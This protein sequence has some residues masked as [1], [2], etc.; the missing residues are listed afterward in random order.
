M[1]EI[2]HNSGYVALGNAIVAQAAYDY[3]N[4]LELRYKTPGSL[5]GYYRVMNLENFLRSEWCCFISSIDSEYI[6]S[7]CRKKVKQ[8]YELRRNDD[9][10]S[11]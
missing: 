4:A 2:K 7:Y 6:I 10:Q 11:I 5:A 9:V 3:Y 1:S 8:K